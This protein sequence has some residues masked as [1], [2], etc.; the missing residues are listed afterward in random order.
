MNCDMAQG[1]YYAKPMPEGEV[2]KKLTAWTPART[3]TG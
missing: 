1:Y 2:I 3:A